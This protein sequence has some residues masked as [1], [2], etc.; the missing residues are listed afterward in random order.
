MDDYQL[1]NVEEAAAI[2]GL[3]PSTVRGMV[4]RKTIPVFRPAGKRVVRLRRSDV[5]RLLHGDQLGTPPE[6]P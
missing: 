4:Q 1:I 5:L 2:L 6:A 3:R